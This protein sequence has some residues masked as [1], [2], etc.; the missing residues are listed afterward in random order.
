MAVNDEVH[1]R[2]E[3]APAVVAARDGLGYDDA[4]RLSQRG[5]QGHG[6]ADIRI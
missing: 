1:D 6:I 5:Q 3:R 2:L 4:V